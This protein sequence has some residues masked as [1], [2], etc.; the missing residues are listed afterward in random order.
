MRVKRTVTDSLSEESGASLTAS[1]VLHISPSG[2]DDTFRMSALVREG[3][4]ALFRRLEAG[5]G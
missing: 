2:G 5:D 3:V 4:M 1:F